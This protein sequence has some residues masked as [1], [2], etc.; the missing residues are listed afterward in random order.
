M[1][2]II[3]TVLNLIADTNSSEIVSDTMAL[4]K[5][6][7]NNKI[8]KEHPKSEREEWGLSS[9]NGEM[10]LGYM[11]LD[12]DK[13]INVVRGIRAN[14]DCSILISELVDDFYLKRV[15]QGWLT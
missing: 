13:V 8:N 10:D 3:T 14:L 12:P 5:M 7:V 4:I 1:K 9:F 6:D 11:V 15:P 2:E